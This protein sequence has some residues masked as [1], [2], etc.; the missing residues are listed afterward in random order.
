MYWISPTAYGSERN[1]SFV[2]LSDRYCSCPGPRA[3]RTT[4]T[5][6]NRSNGYVTRE[7]PWTVDRTVPRSWHIALLVANVHR[8]SLQGENG[9]S[10]TSTTAS[11]LRPDGRTRR[12]PSKTGGT[13]PRP[14]VWLRSTHS[15]TRWLMKCHTSLGSCATRRS[16][17]LSLIR[18]AYSEISLGIDN[19]R[20]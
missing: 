3:P 8:E 6:L 13:S 7:S 9:A 4:T 12:A 15:P 16:R 17:G 5:H 11:S 18:T 10:I 19:D 14:P 2:G 1:C 20:R